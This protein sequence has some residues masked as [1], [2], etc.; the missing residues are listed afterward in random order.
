MADFRE[1]GDEI[2]VPIKQR[3]YEQL[4]AARERSF[5]V[6]LLSLSKV[7]LVRKFCW[8]WLLVVLRRP[9]WLQDV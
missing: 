5:G 4:S 2:R 7:S 9:A 8:P 6:D 1:H 3:I